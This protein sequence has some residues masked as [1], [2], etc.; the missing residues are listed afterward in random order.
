MC[1]VQFY[2][3]GLSD[4]FYLCVISSMYLL[5]SQIPIIFLTVVFF[6]TFYD[7][8]YQYSVSYLPREENPSVSVYVFTDAD[9]AEK[10]DEVE[11]A[12]KST[13]VLFCSLVVDFLQVQWIKERYVTLYELEKITFLI[14]NDWLP[15]MKYI[16]YTFIQNYQYI[17]WF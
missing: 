9:I 10:P 2:I 5:Y 16:T 12:L 7:F 15:Q 14:E 8:C 1:L 17:E 6:K 4:L 13:K 3:I 11:K